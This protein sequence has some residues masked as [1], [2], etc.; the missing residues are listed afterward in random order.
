MQQNHIVNVGPWNGIPKNATNSIKP[1]QKDGV[2]QT[3][4][5]LKKRIKKRKTQIKDKYL[6][7][8]GKIKAVTI[9][10]GK[11]IIN[12]KKYNF[13]SIFLKLTIKHLLIFLLILM[14]TN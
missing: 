6:Y 2:K 3:V 7:N 14:I 11:I 13:Q 1:L 12:N 8:P 9:A 5:I 10:N 4:K